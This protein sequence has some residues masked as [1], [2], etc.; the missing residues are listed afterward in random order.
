VKIGIGIPNTVLGTTG[1]QMIEWARR[2]ERRGFSTLATI[3]RLAYAS[4]DSL[5]S[6]A[7]VAGA[8]E[9]IG[10][11]TNVLL[12]PIYRP[13]QLAKATASL[14]QLS[15][16]RFTL[17]IGIGTRQDDYALADANFQARGRQL[18]DLLDYLSRSWRGEIDPPVGPTA[19]GGSVPLLIGG[20]PRYAA[21]RAVTYGAAWTI[22]G[23]GAEMAAQGA[24]AFRA[25]WKEHG[26]QGEARVVALQYFSLGEG[27]V[28]ESKHNLRS[29]YGY[30]DEWV[31]AIV[32]YQPRDEAA[33]R[34]TVKAFEDIG[35]EELVFDPTISDPAQVDA[36]A[37][38]VL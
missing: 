11:L 12:G 37:D 27:N 25:A 6:L 35:V 5:V 30:L 3:D 2:A 36:L 7:A 21:P 31:D 33:I 20:Q 8:T 9:R 24:E 29:Y 1:D 10:L 4:Y 34:Q 26:G 23:G 13:A 22:G 15:G 17:G 28:E 38:I 18:D 19:P 32:E 14:A 16:G